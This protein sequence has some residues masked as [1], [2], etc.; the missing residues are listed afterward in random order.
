MAKNEETK[1][2]EDVRQL[3]AER[4]AEL[5]R[6]FSSMEDQKDIILPMIDDV[7]FLEEQLMALRKLPQIRVHP[8]YPDIQKQTEAAKL[9]VKLF[10][11]YNQ[12]IKTLTGIL[13]KDAAEEESPLR[14]FLKSRGG[15]DD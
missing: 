11:Q 6:I 14:A 1:Q 15:N 12:A 13:R 2:N 4:K 5:L 8:E 9:Y 3:S 10:Q 7:V